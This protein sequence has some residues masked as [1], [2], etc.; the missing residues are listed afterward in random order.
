MSALMKTTSW[1]ILLALWILLC[2]G[3]FL[4]KCPVLLPF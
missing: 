4:V 1:D 2:V 3:L